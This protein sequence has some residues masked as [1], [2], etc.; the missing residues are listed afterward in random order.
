M[1]KGGG[2][3]KQDAKEKERTEKEGKVRKRKEKGNRRKGRERGNARKEMC[4]P[5]AESWL[6]H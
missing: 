3:G 6:H 2:E 4:R 5:T 1:K